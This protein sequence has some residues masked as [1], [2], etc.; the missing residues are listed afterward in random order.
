M[1]FKCLQIMCAKYMSLGACFEKIFT[2]PKWARL[3]NTA[4]N[5]ALFSKS[6]LKDE[7]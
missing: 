2:S 4:S 6:S 7:S 5:F 3:L 1:M